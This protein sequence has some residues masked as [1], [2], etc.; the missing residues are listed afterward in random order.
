MK[1]EAVFY[2]HQIQKPTWIRHVVVP[3]HTDSDEQLA[4]LAQHIARYTDIVERVEI[5]PYHTMG[6]YKY[7]ELQIPYPFD[8]TPPLSTERK[9]N[10]IRIFKQHI[11][12]PVI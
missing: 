1:F 3:G 5:L 10:A 9:E 7:T 4:A 11:S 8:G 12:C 2:A 6:I